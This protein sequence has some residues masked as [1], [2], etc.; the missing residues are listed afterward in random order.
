MI[1]K[2]D[3]DRI[4]LLY[5]KSKADGLTEDEIAEQKA[6]RQKY[7][8]HIKAQVKLQLGTVKLESKEDLEDKKNS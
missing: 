3:I 7:I 4:N 2:E 8:K 1:T 5:K 6:L